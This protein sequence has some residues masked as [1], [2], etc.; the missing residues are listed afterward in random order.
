MSSYYLHSRETLKKKKKEKPFFISNVQSVNP[1]METSEKA[2][3]VLKSWL[4]VVCLCELLR[5]SRD[6]P[7]ACPVLVKKVKKQ[8]MPSAF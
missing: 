6:G 8:G 2:L 1:V 3:S 4:L 5:A 7:F